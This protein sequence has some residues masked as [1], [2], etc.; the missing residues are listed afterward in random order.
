MIGFVY[1]WMDSGR[2]SVGHPNRRM[3]CLGSHCGTED[4]GY[5]TCTGGKWFADSYRK[6][7]QDF[8]RRIIERIYEGNGRTVFA[9]EQRWLNLIN[10]EELSNGIRQKYYNV[11]K[12]ALGLSREDIFRLHRADPNYGKRIGKGIKD[13]HKTDPTIG[14]RKSASHKARFLANP[15]LRKQRGMISRNAHVR[16]PELGKRQAATRREREI[17]DP[18]INKRRA[19][20]LKITLTAKR[21]NEVIH[22]AFRNDIE[23]WKRL[24]T[25]LFEKEKPRLTIRGNRWINNGIV[26]QYLKYNEPLPEGWKFGHKIETNVNY[27]QYLRQGISLRITYASRPD[28]IEG[29][30]NRFKDRRWINLNGT[31]FR[32]IKPNEEIPKGWSL[33]RKP[34]IIQ[35]IYHEKPEQLRLQY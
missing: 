22:A 26:R 33:G 29:V 18:K 31:K 5:I 24:G 4:D 19:E 35:N 1:L 27:E 14:Q 16:D 9:A 7:P 6:R 28:L 12:N 23:F 11:K 34:K 3:F 15:E 17:A 21:I 13:A 25:S 32:M 8:K 20:T 10:P 30:R 2:H